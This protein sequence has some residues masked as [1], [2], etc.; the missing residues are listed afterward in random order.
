VADADRLIFKRASGSATDNGVISA[1]I[2]TVV[3]FGPQDD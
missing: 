3:V 2:I 1:L